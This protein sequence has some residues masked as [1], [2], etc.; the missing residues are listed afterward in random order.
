MAVDDASPDESFSE[1]ESSA[2][3]LNINLFKNP[4][5]F[6]FGATVNRG[7]ALAKGDVVV[8]LNSDVEFAGGQQPIAILSALAASMDGNDIGAVMPIIFSNSLG[9]VENLNFIWPRRGLLWLKRL[10]ET[11]K[12][13]D[14]AKSFIENDSVDGEAPPE[15]TRQIDSAL[16]G[17]FF[18]MLRRDFL[19]LGGFDTRFSPFYWEDV[20]LGERI[21][22]S[23]LRVVADTR[24]VA[25]HAHGKSIERA[26]NEET[27]WLVM[28]KNQVAFTRLWGA[29]Y[30]LGF[31]G[32]WRIL[33]GMRALTNGNFELAGVYFNSAL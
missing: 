14:Y 26:A 21:R 7:V 24:L 29:N 12:I 6:G 19:R 1:L 9:E 15:Q 3:E 22:K 13:T 31:G 17:A 23:G 30:G 8:I 5:N 25:L 11:E 28:F 32:C 20:E 18:A 10:D 2:P 27:K 4:S 33:R 16:C